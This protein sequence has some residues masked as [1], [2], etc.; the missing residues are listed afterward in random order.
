MKMFNDEF[1]KTVKTTI[2]TKLAA[3]EKVTRPSLAE[4]L[5]PDASQERLTAVAGGISCMF[6]L[7][8]FPEFV[9][10]RQTGIIPIEKV[11][12]K[13]A[14]SIESQKK[15]LEK[16]QAKLQKLEAAIASVE[17]GATDLVEA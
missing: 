13:P 2:Q 14:K 8:C 11:K 17:K 9:M 7:G 12:D 10:Q 5:Y 16:T 1:I 3:G 6:E 4:T 15:E